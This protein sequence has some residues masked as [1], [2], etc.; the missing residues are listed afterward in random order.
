MKELL[1]H[2]KDTLL[3]ICE[4]MKKCENLIEQKYEKK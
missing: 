3:I 1:N 4:K 2:L